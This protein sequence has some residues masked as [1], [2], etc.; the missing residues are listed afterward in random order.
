MRGSGAGRGAEDGEELLAAVWVGDEGDWLIAECVEEFVWGERCWC[1]EWF[2]GGEVRLGGGGGDELGD[3]GGGDGE[4]G[5]GGEGVAERLTAL[6]ETAC[7]GDEV[8]GGGGG[9]GEVGEEIV[10]VHGVWRRGA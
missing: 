2:G 8:V 4:D 10:R 3:E 1:G 5:G 6:G 9:R 7:G